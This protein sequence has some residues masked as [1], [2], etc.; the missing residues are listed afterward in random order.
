ML[1]LRKKTFKSDKEN[2]LAKPF[3]TTELILTTDCANRYPQSVF[4]FFLKKK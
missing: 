4:H 3:G 1:F 2:F